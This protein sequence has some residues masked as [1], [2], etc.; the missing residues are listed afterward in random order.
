MALLG[1]RRRYPT[2]ATMEI[3]FAGVPDASVIADLVCALLEELDAKPIDATT[4]AAIRQRANAMIS[5]GS[6]TAILAFENSRAVGLATLHDCSAI[7]A[8]RFGE[9]SEMYVD[10]DYRNCKIGSSLIFACIDHAKD[11]QWA[12]LEVG[13]PELPKWKRTEAF[14]DRNGFTTVGARMKREMNCG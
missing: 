8:G 7:Y 10:P 14:Y 2:D 11:R 13:T 1:Q 9:I 12:R 4:E 3:R 6:V 5:D